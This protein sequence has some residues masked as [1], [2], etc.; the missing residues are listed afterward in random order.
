MILKSR[1][2]IYPTACMKTRLLKSS[3]ENYNLLHYE[4]M[5]IEGLTRGP[6]SSGSKL[7]Q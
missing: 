3:M 2:Y 4:Q 1:K 5:Y 6:P 7:M